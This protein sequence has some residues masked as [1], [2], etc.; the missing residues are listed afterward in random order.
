[1]MNGTILKLPDFET[2][3]DVLEDREFLVSDT[4]LR[5]LQIILSG[6]IQGVL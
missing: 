3:L 5:L 1:M 4:A 6:I 2:V